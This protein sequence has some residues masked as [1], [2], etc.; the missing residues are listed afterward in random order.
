MTLDTDDSTETGAGALTLSHPGPGGGGWLAAGASE[1]DGSPSR[2]ARNNG[3]E[4]EGLDLGDLGCR[5]SRGY[6]KGPSRQ[7]LVLQAV[8]APAGGTS[9]RAP[10]KM[11]RKFS[12]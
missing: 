8:R 7:M 12:A 11:R 6:R 4:G 2:R 1:A 9:T 10:G 3:L 5:A